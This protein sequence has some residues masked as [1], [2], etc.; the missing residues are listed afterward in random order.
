MYPHFIGYAPLVP[1]V[2]AERSANGWAGKGSAR[3]VTEGTQVYAARLGFGPPGLTFR[4]DVAQPYGSID[5]DVINIVHSRC[6]MYGGYP[7]QLIGAHQYSTFMGGEALSLLADLVFRTN[8]K[9]KENPSMGVLF[10]PFG[11]YGK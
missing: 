2:K 5:A 3:A 1:A 7:K 10:Q 8:A 11:A 4:V 6:A 9:V